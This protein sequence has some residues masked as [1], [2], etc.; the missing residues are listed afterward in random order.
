MENL[1]L[2]VMVSR[3]EAAPGRPIAA[4]SRAARI[5]RCGRRADATADAAMER[6]ADLGAERSARIVRGGIGDAVPRRREAAGYHPAPHWRP[7]PMTKSGD[8]DAASRARQARPPQAQ[9]APSGAVVTH[10][11]KRSAVSRRDD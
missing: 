2:Q 4:S 10:T 11:A 5:M 1:S 3:A 8:A 9:T 6:M 7:G